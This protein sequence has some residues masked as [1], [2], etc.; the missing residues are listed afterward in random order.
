MTDSELRF[1]D[2]AEAG[3]MLGERLAGMDPDRPIIYGLP[4]GG[5]PIALE[6]ARKLGAPLDLVFV[7]KISAP[8]SPEVALGAIVDGA[9]PQMVINEAVRRHSHA[10]AAYLESERARELEELERRRK[11]YLGDHKQVSPEGHTAILVDDG[12]ATGATM[13][14]ALLGLRQQGA[15]QIWIAVP[16]APA[17]AIPEFEEIAD[18][19]VCLNPTNRFYGVGAFYDDFHQLSDEETVSLLQQGWGANDDPDPT[20]ATGLMC[21]AV[22]IPPHALEG[23]LTVPADPKGLVIFAHGSGSSRLS[24]RNRAVAE[25]LNARGFATLLFD[26]LTPEEAADRRNVFDIPLLAERITETVLYVSGEPDIEDLPVGLFGASTGAGAALVAAAGLGERIAAVVSRGGRPDLAGAHLGAVTAPSLLIVGGDDGQVL[27]L[28]RSALADLT[29][30]KALRIVPG[31]THLFEEPGTLEMV[32]AMAGDWFVQHLTL[33]ATAVHPQIEDH[34]TTPEEIATALRQAIH[35]LPEIDDPAF[36]EAFDRYADA[37]VVLLGEASHGTSEFYRARAAITRRLIEKHGFTHVCVEADWPDAAAIDRHIRNLPPRTGRDD[38]FTRFPTWMWRNREVD[39][40]IDSLRA[41]NAQRTPDRQVRFA[42]LDLYSLS[43]SIS[44]VLDYLD[45]IDP[46]AAKEARQ[47]YA[48]FDPWSHQLAAYGRASLS[49]GYALC[50]DPVTRTLLDL[51]EGELDYSARDGDDFFDAVQNARL[52][53]NAERYYRVMYYASHETWNLRDRHMF[54]TLERI[55]ER[56]GPDAKA[57]VWAHNSHIGD[58]RF[59]D[60]GRTRNEWN[61]GQ[62][63]REAY[64]A[65]AALIGFGTHTGTVAAAS[66][67]DA[68]MEVKSV[69]PSRP[70]SYEALCHAT[71]EARFLLDLGKTL[72]AALQRALSEPRLERYIGVIYRPETERWSHYS[73]A[74]L[75]DQYDG[76]VWFDETKAVTAAPAPF[77][78]GEDDTFPFGL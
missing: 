59:T 48:C 22:V 41:L 65:E 72:P 58:A 61:I 55:L 76:F 32:C 33:P 73:H 56:G 24:P 4:R 53:A 66:E 26:L 78:D 1:T 21:R 67:W 9:H 62:L 19:V 15:A 29:C 3:R 12:L 36:A 46:E 42:G 6:V 35:P 63:C 25:T 51:L 37:R 17:S 38:P 60:M 16:V 71:G 54:E 13:K 70:D 7:R 23:D 30:E 8:G 69:R 40:F 77:R 47:R 43:A 27:A 39:D 31:A 50:E 10:D 18:R 49:H 57:V 45:G 34:L 14:A 75:P 64:G 28:N 44:A 74:T 52:V 2:R 11:R 5:V 20:E 68:P